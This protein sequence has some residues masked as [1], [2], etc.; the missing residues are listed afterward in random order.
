M[1]ALS[2]EPGK[3]TGGADAV[4]GK[5]GCVVREFPGCSRPV[6]AIRMMAMQS[7]AVLGRISIVLALMFGVAGARAG[8]PERKMFQFGEFTIEASAGDE[9]YAEALALQLADYQPP[10]R[11]EAPTPKL[12]LDDLA[13]RRDYFLGRIASVLALSKPTE[14]MAQTYDHMLM[15]WQKMSRVVPASA[16]RHYALWRRA[17]LLA[18]IDAGE[19]IAGFTKDPSGGL[20]FRFEL[21]VQSDDAATIQNAWDGFVGPIEI[22][23]ASGKTPAEEVGAGLTKILRNFVVEFHDAFFNMERQKV[24]NVLHEAT[25]SGIVWHYL[26]SK[27]RRWFCDGVANYVAFKTIEAEVGEPEARSYYDLSAELN[28]FAGEATRVDLAA[29]PAAEDL[30]KTRYAENLNTA[31]YAFATKVIADVCAR[32][33]DDLLPRLFREIGKTPR[34]KATINTVYKAYRKLTREDLRSYLPKPAGRT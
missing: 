31:D 7:P 26:I 20:N 30:A 9:A 21:N 2:I 8:F 24:F 32:R 3:V 10:T 5:L 22:G 34:E 25:E 18:R 28:K 11:P 27:D 13:R 23:A 6:G 17:E 33:S 19:K 16:P 29:W 4:N 14:K 12:S 15:L 1:P